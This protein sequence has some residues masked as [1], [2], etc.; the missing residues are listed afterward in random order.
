MLEDILATVNFATLFALGNHCSRTSSGKKSR[1]TRPTSTQPF[2][3][4]SLGVKLNLDVTRHILTFEFFV[5]PYIR[6]N[7]LANLA[8]IQQLS[9]PLAI[10]P[11]VI[12]HPGQVFSPCIS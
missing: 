3:K 10:D 7:H 8:C 1:D 12:T 9:Q 6:G 2:C 4:C 11:S 5:F